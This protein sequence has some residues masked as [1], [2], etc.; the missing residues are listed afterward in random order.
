LSGMSKTGA[1]KLTQLEM[2]KMMMKIN[3]L[4]ILN[5]RTQLIAIDVYL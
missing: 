5:Q 4:I 2:T 3:S 1:N